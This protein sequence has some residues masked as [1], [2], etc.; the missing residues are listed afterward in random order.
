MDFGNCAIKG[1]YYMYTH[2]LKLAMFCVVSQNY[3]HF[4]FSS[5]SKL[6]KEPQN[7]ITIKVGWVVLELLID[8][9]FEYFDP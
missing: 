8:Q 4:F 7:S 9:Y 2:N 1:I 6:S 5:W 3:Q